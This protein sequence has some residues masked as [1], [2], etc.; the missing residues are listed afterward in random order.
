[1][2]YKWFTINNLHGFI[3]MAG[4]LSYPVLRHFDSVSNL[5]RTLMAASGLL[6]DIDKPDIF[7]AGDPE[8]IRHPR[9]RGIGRGAKGAVSLQVS[10]SVRPGL[11]RR[12]F[13][14][15]CGIHLNGRLARRVS[16]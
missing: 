11:A 10:R 1:M 7:F 16:R 3:K 13:Q 12:S 9:S 4:R 5:R 8:D 6:L 15:R 2:R 14:F